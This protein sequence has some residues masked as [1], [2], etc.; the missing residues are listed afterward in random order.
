MRA[1]V[2]HEYGTPD[3]VRVEDVDASPLTRG[4]VR[5]RVGAAAVNFP[6]VL[7]VANEYQVHIPTPFVVGS[8][9]AG[10]VSEVADG[11]DRIAVGDHVSGTGIV[12]AFA[13]EV[14]VAAATLSP[15]PPGI[16]F[17]HAAAFGIAHRTSYN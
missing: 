10:V 11:V 6:D 14:A 9:F 5:V 12:G 15:V 8:E 7:I 4:Q 13:E 17:P 1:A 2:C 16:D 3:V